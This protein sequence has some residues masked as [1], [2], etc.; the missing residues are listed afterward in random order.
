MSKLWAI[1]AV[2]L[3]GAAPQQETSRTPAA[4][5]KLDQLIAG[6][7]A[8]E[9]V[10]CVKTEKT[11]SPIGIDDRTMLFRDGPRLWRNDLEAG[12]R[13]SELGMNKSLFTLNKNYQLCRGN[14]VYIVDMKDGST[15]GS[16]V[17]G[18]FVLYT[19]P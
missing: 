6:R 3:F 17:L 13:C 2:L 15:T 12:Y 11:R 18:N 9:P 10:R 7:V 14:N 5:A 1:L 8:G 16:C 19:K 4:Q